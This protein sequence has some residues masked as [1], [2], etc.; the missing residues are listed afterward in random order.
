MTVEW[1]DRRHDVLNGLDTL[2]ATPPLL[3]SRGSAIRWPDLTNAVHWVADDTGW[4]RKDPK[5]SIG[6][7]LVSVEEAEAVASVVREIVSVAERQGP[8]APDRMW[9]DDESWP[10]VQSAARHA[11]DLMRRSDG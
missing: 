2:A 10:R 8:E 1:P 5:Q 6:T 7:L 11:A 9:F 4:D 3:D